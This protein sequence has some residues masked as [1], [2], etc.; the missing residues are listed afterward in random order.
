MTSLPFPRQLKLSASNVLSVTNVPSA[1]TASSF[2]AWYQF[3]EA[4]T[5]DLYHF[6]IRDSTSNLEGFLRGTDKALPGVIGRFRCGRAWDFSTTD[7]GVVIMPTEDLHQFGGGVG[8]LG[9]GGGGS[10]K[11]KIMMGG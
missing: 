5:R 9:G 3:K 6:N 8:G 10:D 11:G 4:P 7:N 1:S 2:L